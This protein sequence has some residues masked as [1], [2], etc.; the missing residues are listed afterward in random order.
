LNIDVEVGLSSKVTLLGS[1]HNMD[2][3]TNFNSQDSQISDDQNN[4]QPISQPQLR[5]EDDL[6]AQCWGL[7]LPCTPG[8]ERVRFLKTKPEITVGR[9]STRNVVLNWTCV[10]KKLSCRVVLFQQLTFD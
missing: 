8:L 4:T 10:S 6:D 5:P 2:V 9:D 1:G 3:S 7:L